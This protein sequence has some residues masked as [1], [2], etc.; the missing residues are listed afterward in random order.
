VSRRMLVNDA[1]GGDLQVTRG[2]DRPSCGILVRRLSGHYRRPSPARAERAPRGGRVQATCGAPRSGVGAK[3]RAWT[4]PSAAAG[5][6]AEEG[7]P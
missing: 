3:R 4:R 7:R 5:V 6:S 2:G 1:N